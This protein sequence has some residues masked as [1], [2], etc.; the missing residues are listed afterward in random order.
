MEQTL[1][2]YGTESHDVVRPVKR[3]ESTG[4]QNKLRYYVDNRVWPSCRKSELAHILKT[5]E[6]SGGHQVDL[7]GVN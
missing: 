7:Q 5:P 1:L 3:V 2:L 6:N 4:Q